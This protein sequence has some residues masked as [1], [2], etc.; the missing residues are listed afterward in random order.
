MAQAFMAMGRPGTVTLLQ[1]L[2]LSLSVPLMLLLIPRFGVAGAATAL[3][4]STIARAIFL[5]TGFRLFLKSRP[6]NV[7]P[8]PADLRELVTLAR[9]SF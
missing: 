6:P 3:L 8:R 7:I 2:G 9:R 4:L 1:A 5:L